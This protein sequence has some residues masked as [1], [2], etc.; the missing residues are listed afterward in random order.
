MLLDASSLVARGDLKP[1]AL[2]ALGV[3]YLTLDLRILARCRQQAVGVAGPFGPKPSQVGCNPQLAQQRFACRGLGDAAIECQRVED[4]IQKQRK[5]IGF[6]ILTQV[7]SH[8]L[9][10]RGDLAVVGGR[11]A[12]GPSLH[13]FGRDPVDF[14]IVAVAP[15][16]LEP[17]R[18]GCM[19]AVG[20]EWLPDV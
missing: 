9:K 3:C 6:V 13:G 17:D 10:H 1:T 7:G 20:D 14:E 16:V 2:A 18:I 15:F 11:I 5:P 8:R 19:Q 4:R 12:F